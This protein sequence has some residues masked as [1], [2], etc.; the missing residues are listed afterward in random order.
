[1]VHGKLASWEEH[2][3]LVEFA[4]NRVIH[5][6]IGMTPFEV[7]YGLNPLTPLDLTPLSQ[8]VVLSLDGSK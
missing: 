6:T 8:D 4:Y 3:L 7:V 2:L 1:M 5:R